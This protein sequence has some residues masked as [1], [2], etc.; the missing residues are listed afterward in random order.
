MNTS[1]EIRQSGQALLDA[2]PGSISD[3]L[4]SFVG[5]FVGWPFSVSRGFGTD[6]S[7]LRTEEFACVVH[8][9]AGTQPGVGIPA[10]SIGA[11]IDASADLT[12][13]ELQA[14][15]GRIAQAKRLRKRPSAR[16]PSGQPTTN[17]TLGI[18]LALRS[19]LPFETLAE[20]LDRL[21]IATPGRERVDMVVVVSAGVINYGVQMPTEGVTGDF[22]PP[23]D[24]ALINFTPPW[25][26]V[27]LL[28]PTGGL[29]LNKMMAFL[30]AHLGIFSP[31]AKLPNWLEALKN[32]P[33][34][35]LTYRG[36][37]YNLSGELVPVPPE[38][39]ND[40]YLAPLPVSIESHRGKLL[41]LLRF[42]PWQDGGVLLLEQNE[43]PLDPFRFS[44][45]R[46]AE[47]GRS[48]EGQEWPDLIRTPDHASRL[49]TD[50]GR[51]CAPIQHDR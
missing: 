14:A 26:I 6:D 38:F 36:Y 32:V 16:V 24:G 3:A 10:D 51:V 44:R 28:R 2:Q 5:K 7:G 1:E 20:E 50:V 11:V 43:I 45:P 40:R 47:A 21:N 23:G 42:L 31:G 27:M 33:G 29:S 13:A 12:I 30:I 35:G 19:S 49:P 4:G 22:L 48:Y 39:Y 34:T 18:I 15:F 41:G 9:A 46:C 37:Q 8:T 25:Y 17:V